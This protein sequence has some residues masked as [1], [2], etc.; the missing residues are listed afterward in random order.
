MSGIPFITQNSFQGQ[1]VSIYENVLFVKYFG[2]F[3]GLYVLGT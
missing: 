2:I 1:S 3:N